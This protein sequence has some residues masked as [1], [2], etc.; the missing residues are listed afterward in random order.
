MK[1]VTFGFVKGLLVGDLLR[2]NS[3]RIRG[4]W[5]KYA[6]LPESISNGTETVC[7]PSLIMLIPQRD[8]IL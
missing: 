6:V 2:T 1:S 4:K 3:F 7:L 5:I 8:V